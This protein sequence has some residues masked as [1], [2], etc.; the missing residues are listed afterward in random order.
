MT[1]QV[2]TSWAGM[3]MAG[4][5]YAAVGTGTAQAAEQAI[6]NRDV[7][8]ALTEAKKQAAKK[9]W[10]AALASLDKADGVAGKSAYADYKIDEFRAYVLTQQRQ[11]GAAAA[12][13]EKLAGSSEAPSAQVPTQLKT[14]AQL[15]SRAGQN[16]KAAQVGQRA[17]KLRP[18]DS[19]LLQLVGQSQYTAKNYRAAAATMQQLVSLSEKQGKKPEE[20]WLQIILNSQYQVNDKDGIARSWMSLLRYYPKQQYWERVLDMKTAGV[21]PEPI[22]LGYQRLMFDVGVLK[23]PRDYEDLAMNSI[24][25]GAPAEAVRVLQ[26]GLQSGQFEGASEARFKRMLEY[27]Q[28][29]VAADEN[30]LQQE[31]QTAQSADTGQ[32][33]VDLGRA[34]LGQ[35]RYDDAISALQQGIK[36]GK[37]K[38][39]DQAR[40][41]LGIA[42]LRKDERRQAQQTFASVESKSEWRDL[43]DLW[44]LHA[45]TANT[46]N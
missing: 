5:L 21:Q 37:L 17:L 7:A 41:D 26:H 3:L 18:Q 4:L 39:E 11:Y 16:A 13:F 14:A 20:G 35:Q 40:L 30:K 9:Q 29:A 10:S 44:R 19:E 24:E 46:A 32:P 36:K 28:K 15:Y 22:E 2:S 34:Y 43:A 45:M 8:N 25:S 42:Y 33:S 31:V 23:D 1:K 27:A 38:N 12:V 6:Q